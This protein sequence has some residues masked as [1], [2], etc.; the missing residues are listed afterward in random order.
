MKKLFEEYVESADYKVS[1]FFKEL[2]AQIEKWFSDGSLAAQGC[3]LDGDIQ[4]SNYNP[5]EKFLTVNFT[6]PIKSGEE[7]EGTTFR[8]RVI[9]MVRLDQM[10]GDE[11]QAQ[12]Q[13]MQGQGAQGEAPV[14]TPAEGKA[15][16]INKVLLKIHQFD[17]NNKEKG[18]LVEEVAVEDIKE[19]FMIDKIGQLKDK[20]GDR[21]I[22]SNDLKD[23]ISVE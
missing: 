5:M 14:E 17:E 10:K 23:N 22:D 11:A 7:E 12:G 4:I 15:L 16:E 9:F 20:S 8:Y 1:V 3:E 19:D 18:E 6:E 13:G 21:G 2:E